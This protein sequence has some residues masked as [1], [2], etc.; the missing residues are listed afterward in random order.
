M[1]IDAT[2]Y[3]AFWQSP[4]IYRLRYVWNL[5]TSMPEI[6]MERLMLRGR[7]RGSCFHELLDGKEPGNP[8]Y[9][10]EEI[11]AAEEMAALYRAKYPHELG[12]RREIEFEYAIPD[13]VHVMV[14]RIDLVL[15]GP[16][17]IDTKTC[18]KTT[19]KEFAQRVEE[20]RASAQVSFYLLGADAR[21]F[22]HRIVQK[23]QVTEVHTTRTGVELK[24]F[25]RN[26]AMTCDIIEFMK[27]KFGTER[28]WPSLHTKYR[29][30]YAAI[31]GTNMYDE[32][33]PDG[34]LLRK[35][36]L[37]VMEKQNG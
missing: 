36:H 29:S 24:R 37:S 3:A 28:P 23:D 27:E 10:A 20:Y 9:N 6:G 12:V 21:T 33:I 30:G 17:V 18:G 1:L 11:A 22:T 25:A 4:E 15:P 32:Y 13:S 14:G 8:T 19:K 34:F 2:R 26:V 31:E 7:Q 16:V 35:E 5:I